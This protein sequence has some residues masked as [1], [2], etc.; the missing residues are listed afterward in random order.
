M[1][2]VTLDVRP[3]R[4]AAADFVRAGKLASVSRRGTEERRLII[5]ANPSSE[6]T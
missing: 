2:T 3:A 4:E 6:V 5:E 1:K